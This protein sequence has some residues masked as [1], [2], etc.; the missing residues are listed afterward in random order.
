MYVF[1]LVSISANR[2]DHAKNVW[3]ELRK[4]KAEAS[5]TDPQVRI[6]RQ[7]PDVNKIKGNPPKKMT[8]T[9]TTTK[10]PLDLYRE[11]EAMKIKRNPKGVPPLKEQPIEQKMKEFGKKLKKLERETAQKRCTSNDDCPN[12]T[13]CMIDIGDGYCVRPRRHLNQLCSD[14]CPCSKKDMECKT[15]LH[16]DPFGQ[17]KYLKKCSEKNDPEKVNTKLAEIL[18]N[19]KA[20]GARPRVPRHYKRGTIG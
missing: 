5:P 2:E 18:S 10:S 8:E 14:F 19:A 4:R 16:T 9:T 15:Q 20:Q 12:N 3:L 11:H 7:A 6:H 1:S 13:C 17:Y